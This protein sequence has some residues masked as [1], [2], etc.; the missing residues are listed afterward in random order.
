MRT[1]MDLDKLRTLVELSR[2]GTMA[3]VAEATGYGTSAISQQ[4]AALE[5][6]VERPLLEASGRRVRLTPAGRRLVAHAEGILAAVTAAERDLASAAEPGGVVRVA[7]YTTALRRHVVPLAAELAERYPLLRAARPGA[8]A[9]RDRRAA[10][11]RPDRPRL[12][13]RLQPGAARRPRRLHL[14]VDLRDEAGGAPRSVATRADS[15]PE[16]SGRHPRRGVDRQLAGLRRRRAGRAAVCARRLVSRRSGTGP[17]A[18]TSWSTWC[19][20]RAASA[21]WPRTRPSRP[22]CATVSIEFARPERRMW[23][24]V[25]D[26]AQ[27]WPATKAVIDAVRR[28]ADPEA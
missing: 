28:H 16:G 9:G 21:C 1:S 19:W 10:R 26:G 23:S 2:R 25:P 27:D 18:S 4:L 11:R 22:G 24:V 13:L 14:A 6:Q 20:P 5:R 8:G 15:P 3:A 12:R 17:T 7:G